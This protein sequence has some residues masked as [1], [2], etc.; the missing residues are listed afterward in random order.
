MHLSY[1]TS[2]GN[3]SE[4]TKMHVIQ[5]NTDGLAK[6][7]S[8]EAAYGAVFGGFNGALKDALQCL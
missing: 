5:I 4:L 3:V 8:G 6:G 2:D 7:N 1:Q